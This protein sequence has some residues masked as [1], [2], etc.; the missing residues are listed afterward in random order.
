MNPTDYW[1]AKTLCA[2]RWILLLTTL[3]LLGPESRKELE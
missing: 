1:D 3:P 2:A